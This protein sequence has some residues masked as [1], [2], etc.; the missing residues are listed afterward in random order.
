[1]A[2]GVAMANCCKDLFFNI[3]LQ[4]HPIAIAI[5]EVTRFRPG[6]RPSKR[7]SKM[8][9]SLRLQKS[10]TKMDTKNQDQQNRSQDRPCDPH[11]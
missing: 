6:L 8:S 10:K 1:M 9:K 2:T 5:A 3:V 7:R 4:P 11:H